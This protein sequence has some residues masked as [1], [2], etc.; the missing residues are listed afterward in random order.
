MK[1]SWWLP[2]TVLMGR[3]RALLLAQQLH[4]GGAGGR[5][6]G[7]VAQLADG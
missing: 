1:L 3:Q 2:S 7:A 5:G 4:G 6:N